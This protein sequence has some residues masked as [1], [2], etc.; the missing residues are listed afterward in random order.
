MKPLV[1]STAAVHDIRRTKRGGK[2]AIPVVT[3]R[4]PPAHLTQGRTRKPRAQD[5]WCDEIAI[6]RAIRQ[7]EPV[8]RALTWA[9]KQEVARRLLNQGFSTNDVARCTR[10]SGTTLH[11]LLA[12]IAIRED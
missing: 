9:E 7:R 10:S 5:T 6:E 4:E 1:G 11:Q 8:G 2:W 12:D 3:H